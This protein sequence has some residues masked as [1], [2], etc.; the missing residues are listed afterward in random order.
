MLKTKIQ[1]ARKKQNYAPYTFL[2]NFNNNILYQVIAYNK[3]SSSK[4]CIN[5][6]REYNNILLSLIH[7]FKFI[8]FANQ[9][10]TMALYKAL[11]KLAD[12]YGNTGDSGVLTGVKKEFNL[13]N[14]ENP[15]SISMKR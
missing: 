2:S 13:L 10:F 3:D 12:I 5:I 7:T 9:S 1:S 15:Y 6:L 11:L 14:S 4:V 8:S